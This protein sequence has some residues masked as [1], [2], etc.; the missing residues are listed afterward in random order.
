MA[1]TWP[2]TACRIS[3]FSWAAAC[4]SIPATRKARALW[5]AGRCGRCRCLARRS[6]TCE[7]SPAAGQTQRPVAITFSPSTSFP[8]AAGSRCFQA[9]RRTARPCSPWYGGSSRFPAAEAGVDVVVHHA[10][11]LHEGVADGGTHEAESPPLELL[12]HRLGLGRVRRNLAGPPVV[13]P[14]LAAHELPE[15]PVERARL[16]DDFE[17]GPGVLDR[18]RDLRLVAD[19]PRVVHQLVDLDPLIAGDFRGI[20]AV[21]RPAVSFA[22][23]QDRDPRQSRLRSL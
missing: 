23:P 5:R 15:E 22:P 9:L 12:A 3:C 11:G 17:E 8:E 6:P 18:R 10:D 1:R 19:D 2:G 14:G 20:E 21:E 16:L 4:C 7:T 13:H